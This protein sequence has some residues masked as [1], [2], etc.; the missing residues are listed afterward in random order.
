MWEF[1]N[2]GFWSM[3]REKVGLGF[4][5]DECCLEME[6]SGFLVHVSSVKLDLWRLCGILQR[7]FSCSV[8]LC[9]LMQC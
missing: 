4:G 8:L 1:F 6:L 5:R 9:W 7:M 3:R 2:E